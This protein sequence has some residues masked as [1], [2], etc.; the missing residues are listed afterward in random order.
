MTL[1][2]G[3]LT[4]LTFLSAILF[5]WPL[6]AFL[7]CIVSSVEP[8]V[9]LAAG[10]FADVL[11]YTPGAG[12]FPLFTVSGLILSMIAAF[13]RSQLRPSIIRR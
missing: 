12:A 10:L 1:R 11:Y 3:S 5:P 13:V 6:T 8:L 4:I 2:N 7:A 9:P